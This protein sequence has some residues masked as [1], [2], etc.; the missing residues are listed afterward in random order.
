MTK[1]NSR[2]MKIVQPLN[3]TITVKKEAP[4]KLQLIA[5]FHNVVVYKFK[6]FFI[7]INLN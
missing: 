6:S 2:I 1:E 4:E 3:K 5:L 7:K